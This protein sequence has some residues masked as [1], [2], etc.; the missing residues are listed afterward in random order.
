[1]LTIAP[2]VE[3]S[4]AISGVAASTVVLEMGARNEQNDKR[5]TMISFRCAGSLS[6]TSSG[7]STTEEIGSTGISGP[8]EWCVEHRSSSPSP[9]LASDRAAGRMDSVVPPE[10][11]EE[12]LECDCEFTL[13]PRP[14]PVA[15]G[16]T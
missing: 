9:V 13:A 5:K 6:Y 2:V 15:W 10:C 1:M 12:L 16:R 4:S 8:S 7:I 11:I 14:G 3:Y